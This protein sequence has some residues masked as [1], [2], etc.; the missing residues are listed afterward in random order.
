MRFLYKNC[1]IFEVLS[2]GIP[3][4]RLSCQEQLPEDK[5]PP[6]FTIDLDFEISSDDFEL[7]LK[8]QLKFNIIP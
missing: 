8:F 1:Q 7:L 4:P 5:I 3:N 6:I 2:Q